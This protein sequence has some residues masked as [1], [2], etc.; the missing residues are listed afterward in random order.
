MF[1]FYESERQ[2]TR[3]EK[4]YNFNDYCKKPLELDDPKMREWFFES[5]KRLLY[6]RQPQDP[7]LEPKISEI[8]GFLGLD[9][10]VEEADY[11]E[12]NVNLEEIIQVAI[13]HP[14]KK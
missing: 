9:H 13:S 6:I 12:L 11:T 4:E 7:D 1:G 14:D 3:I 8:A 10:V 5:Y 2:E